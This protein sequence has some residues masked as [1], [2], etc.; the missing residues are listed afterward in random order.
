MSSSPYILKQARWGQRLQHSEMHDSVWEILTDPVIG[1]LMGETAENLAEKYDISREDQDEVSVRSHQNAIHAIEN[2][3]F[4]EEIIPIEA[5]NKK[6]KMLIGNDEHPRKD[7][8]K[9]KIESL[10]PIFR[11]NG[12]VT[13]A[14]S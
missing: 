12:T 8:S 1:I 5:T 6:K 11:E 14:N 2:G 9:G 3:T 13:A 10:K 4:Q 7:I